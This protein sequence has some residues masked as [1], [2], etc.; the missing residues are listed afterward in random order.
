MT[1]RTRAGALVRAAAARIGGASPVLDAELLLAH[2]IGCSRERLLL[3]D[4]P[5][6]EAACARFEALVIRR[7]RREPV[8]YILGE[9]EFWSLGLRVT[10]DVL[11]PRPDSE[12]LVAG[13]LAA[14][15]GRSPA[16]VLDLGVGSGALLLAVLSEWPH[17]FGVGVDRSAAAV[18]VARGNAAALGL[19]GRAAFM[20]GDW[21]DAL[22]GGFDLL[23][24]NPPYVPEAEQLMADVA[25]YE[26]VAALYGGRDGMDP[27]R[28]L[29]GAVGRLLAAG[30][31]AL[32]EF[33][34]GQQQPLA[35][36]AAAHGYR[37]AFLHDLAGR[38]RA[39][40]LGAG[41]GLGNDLASR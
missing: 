32:F 13:A 41:T 12:V 20:V 5:V 3:G 27:Y 26:P 31:V 10:P 19:A 15:Q 17:A 11:I 34:A 6:P 33:G 21:G 25:D 23:L 16:R 35:E 18:M 22:A 38:A 24:C 37:P 36:L 14:M 28:I 30:G 4:P 1:A 40:R 7:T 39:I 8:A 9:R 2:A 29:F